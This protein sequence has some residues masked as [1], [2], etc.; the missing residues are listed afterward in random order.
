MRKFLLTTGFMLALLFAA[1][2]KD[3]QAQGNIDWEELWRNVPPPISQT[4]HWLYWMVPSRSF[5]GLA[6]DKWRDV[7]YIINPHTTVVGGVSF[8]QDP[9]IWAWKAMTG[10]LATD[11]GRSA[12]SN[13]SGLGGEL[14]VPIDSVAWGPGGIQ[15]YRGYS[16]NTYSLYKIDLDDE[17]RIF[18][19][20]LVVP[21]WGICIRLP[22]GQ[23]DPVYLAQSAFRVWRWDTP[24]ATPRLAYATLNLAGTAI[25]AFG[26]SEMSYT[27]WGDAFDVIGKRAMFYPP[28]DDPYMVDSVRIYVSGGSWPTQPTWNDE[29]NVI[30]QDRRPENQRPASDA[31]SYKLDY[32]LAVRLVNSNSG[33]A[34]HGVAG[35]ANTLVH[36]VWMDSNPRLTTAATHVQ[37]ATDPWPQTYNQNA[38]GNRS[39]STSLTGASGQVRFFE[40]PEYGKKYLVVADG[41]NTGGLDPTIPNKNTTA[42]IIDVTTPG[43]DKNV[44]GATPQLGNKPLNN[45]SGENNYI[46]DVDY[47]LQYY[48]PQEDPLAPGLHVIL[49]VLMS[50]NGIAA[51]RSRNAIPVE[52]TT[53]NATINGENVDLTWSVT[54]ETN[55]YGFEIER[56]FDGG[57]NWENVGFVQGR[58]TT[59][60]PKDYAY[61]DPITV[62]HRNVGNVKYRLR[63]VD[64]DGSYSYSPI[65]DAYFDA[66]PTTITL[67]QNYPNPFNPTTTLSYQ[68]TEP[69][70]ATLKVYNT[71]GEYISTLVDEY[72]EAGVHQL[73]MDAKDLPSGNYIYQLNVNGQVQQKKMTVMK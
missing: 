51:Y 23:C 20:N 54:S 26:D 62:T 39:L 60:S 66:T 27:R 35:T 2:P 70:H 38:T 40:L 45:N 41:M 17:G 21:I 8:Y 11:V 48:S 65:V 64:N 46:A 43:G 56:S 72:R 5:T 58:G 50:N 14:P 6:Y 61:S 13:R 68:L 49:F 25:G 31:G 73:T 59:T 10:Q 63:Q 52:L 34:S 9:R 69:G 1:L 36:D 4:N 71:L 55:N 16:Q 22:N 53:L 18:A 12:H 42:R 57:S 24:T 30:M 3:A 32:R 19:G 33:L 47:K 7:V 44:W 37:D 15:Y 29:V 28:D 67:Y